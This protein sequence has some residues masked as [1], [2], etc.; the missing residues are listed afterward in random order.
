MRDMYQ[1]RSFMTDREL[2]VARVHPKLIKNRHYTSMFQEMLDKMS[3]DGVD[4]SSYLIR[5]TERRDKVFDVWGTQLEIVAVP[6]EDA[7]I[8]LGR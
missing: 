1:G 6:L 4:P 7:R 2:D 3:G 5:L 8:L